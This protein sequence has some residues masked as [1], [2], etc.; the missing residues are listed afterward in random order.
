MEIL[1]FW[2]RRPLV[3]LALVALVLL[4]ACGPAPLG[5]GWPAVAVV[6][7][8]CGGNATSVIMVAFND[9]IVLVNPADG[10]D[11][12]LLNQDCEPRPPDSEGKP[13]VWDFRAANREQFYTT[14]LVLD[15]TTLLAVAYDQKLFRVE[16]ST[17]RAEDTVGTPIS[18]YTGHAVTDPTMSDELIYIG[19]NS[20]DLVALDRE[21]LDVIWTFKTEHGVWGKPLLQDNTLY[22][23]SLDHNLYAVNAETGEGLWTLD[24][25]GATT[26]TPLFY[27]GHLYIGSFV[28]KLFEVSLDGQI[29]NEFTTDD[30]VWGTPVVADDIL[31]FADLGGTVY[32]LDTTQ[33]LSLVW[34]RKVATG[35]IRA[36]PVIA[37]DIVI[38]ASR[39]QKIYWL[40]RKDGTQALDT[41]GQPL[42]RELDS[43]I[44]SDILL[45][46]PSEQ[47]K[48]SEPYVVVSTLSPSHALVAYALDNGERIWEYGFK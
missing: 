24:L 10:K 7:N 11:L 47:M 23:S 9:R 18:G 13:K 8:E 36:T 3:G 31:Y 14:P 44:L 39:D 30:W 27:N 1:K 34:K 28:R 6:N 37:D 17:A 4:A 19:L 32:A 26:G 12:I 40:N 5:T 22:F 48:I 15:A 43:P 25:Q 33:K 29:V 21:N 35:A 42:L 16:M 20:K 2:M 46:Q 38:V 45:L 41:E